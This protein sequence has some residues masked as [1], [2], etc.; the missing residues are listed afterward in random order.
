MKEQ[1][2]I[3][4]LT[5]EGFIQENY[6]EEDKREI[7]KYVEIGW[8]VNL[9]YFLNKFTKT[10]KEWYDEINKLV[11][12]IVVHYVKI[13]KYMYVDDICITHKFIEFVHNN[14]PRK[15]NLNNRNDDFLLCDEFIKNN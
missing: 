15:Y 2:I 3:E 7:A 11:K 8:S 4:E 10:Q 12:I 13:K 14:T 6:S 5:K 9:H 1:H